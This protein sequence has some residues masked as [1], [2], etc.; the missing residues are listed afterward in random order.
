MNSASIYAPED[1][2]YARVNRCKTKPDVIREEER[3]EPEQRCIH[4]NWFEVKDKLRAKFA[5][6]TEADVQPEPGKEYEMMRA[7]ERKLHMSPAQLQQ[8][9]AYL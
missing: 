5:I 3:K 6:L 1:S 2:V 8:E 9:I 4:R 7:I